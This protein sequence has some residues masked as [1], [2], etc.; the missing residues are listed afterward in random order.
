MVRSQMR[1]LFTGVLLQQSI[2][3]RGRDTVKAKRC[4]VAVVARHPEGSMENLVL[5]SREVLVFMKPAADA[6]HPDPDYTWRNPMRV[7]SQLC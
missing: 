2:E 5:A 3:E 1:C 7:R 4:T 6:G